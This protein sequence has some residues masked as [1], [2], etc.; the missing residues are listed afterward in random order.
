MF[1][2]E[3]TEEEEVS[4]RSTDWVCCEEADDGP[5]E[6]K[7][8]QGCTFGVEEAWGQNFEGLGWVVLGLWS[9]IMKYDFDTF[10][11]SIIYI[12]FVFF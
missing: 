8:L 9:E 1:P 5:G 4:R 10:S 6:L 2:M 12:L 3:A 11:E 7:Y